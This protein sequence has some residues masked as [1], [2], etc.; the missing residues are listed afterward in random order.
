MPCITINIDIWGALALGTALGLC[1]L[2]AA[3]WIT[4]TIE[5]ATEASFDI[6]V[7]H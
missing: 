5:D 6:H 4:T 1:I 7:D 3:D 2:L